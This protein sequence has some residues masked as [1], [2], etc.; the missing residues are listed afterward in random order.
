MSSPPARTPNLPARPTAITAGKTHSTALTVPFAA[1]AHQN[2]AKLR[3][4][5]TTSQNI[6]KLTSTNLKGE[7]NRDPPA[8]SNSIGI[9][10]APIKPAN[11]PMNSLTDHWRRAD[12][13]S[14]I[15]QA[16]VPDVL[17][18]PNERLPARIATINVLVTPTIHTTA[19]QFTDA[20]RKVNGLVD[21]RSCTNPNTVRPI[22]PTAASKVI[23]QTGRNKRSS[24]RI[25]FTIGPVGR[26]R[27]QPTNAPGITS[28]PAVSK[29][30]PAIP[31][32]T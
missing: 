16:C 10:A 22:Q 6:P 15:C 25:R 12:T 19:G 3:S 14:V 1:H 27:N 4:N 28:G 2:E 5:T 20:T 8:T 18:S 17:S 24:L 11:R 26:Q 23:S 32:V 7:P 29:S 13:G 9:S 31:P 30:S 21:P